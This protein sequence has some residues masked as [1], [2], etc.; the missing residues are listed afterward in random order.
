MQGLTFA[1]ILVAA[2]CGGGVHEFGGTYRADTHTEDKTGCG[3][4]GELGDKQIFKLE[5]ADALAIR[6]YKYELC[7]SVDLCI[8]F[9]ILSLLFT[10]EVADG[11]NDD[12]YDATAAPGGGGC[13]LSHTAGTLR[14]DG[15][16]ARVEW[17]KYSRTASVP[18][19]SIATAKAMAA[20][21]PCVDH[22]LLIGTRLK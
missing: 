20:T 12:S 5:Y 1:I 18:D 16:G 14:A 11:W 21:L 6:G 15:D 9:G 8:D 13:S 19:C 10:D 2:G 7:T 3:A 17:R 22:E 4:G